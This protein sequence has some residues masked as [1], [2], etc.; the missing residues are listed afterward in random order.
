MRS[1]PFL[2]IIVLFSCHSAKDKAYEQWTTYNGTK[3]GLKYSSL[4]QIDTS[5]VQQLTVAWEYHTG[6]ADTVN[7]SQI[8]CNP[9]M[10]NGILYVISPQLKLAALDAATGQQKW[11]F[12]PWTGKKPNIN[13]LRGLTYWEDEKDKRIFYTA[14]S[15]LYAV[16]ALSGKLATT[17]GDSGLIDLHNDL[18]EGA[19]DLYVITTSPGMIYKDQ[20]IIGSRVSERSDAAPGHIRSYDVHTGKLRWIFHT[21]PQPGEYGFDKWE[22]PEVYKHLGGANAWAGFSLDEERGILFAP[23]GAVSFDFYGGMRQG[24]NLFGNCLVALDANTGKRIWHFQNVHHDVW[25]RDLPAPP[26]LVT[27]THEG[28]KVDAV[29]QVTKTGFVFLFDRLNGHPLFPIEERPVPAQSELSGEKLWATQPYPVLPAPFAR[30]LMTES[31]LNYLLPDSSLKEVKERWAGYRKSHMFE[32][33]STQGSVV[34]PGFDGGPEWGGPAV[35]PETGILYVNSNEMAWVLQIVDMQGKQ[36]KK[37]TNLQAGKRLYRN[38]CMS[39]HG[40][41][42]EGGGNFPSLLHIQSKYTI[43]Q[44][45]ELINTGRRMMPGFSRLKEEEKT[46]IAAFILDLKPE[47]SLAYKGPQE[48]VDSFRNLPYSMTGY[49][50]FLSKEGHPAI[51]PPWGTLNA[52]DLNTGKYVWKDTLGEDP[53]FKDKGIKT[54]TENYGAPVVTAG[55]LLFIAATKDGKMRAFNKRTGQLLWE[56]TLP[57]AGFATPAVYMVNGKQY[58]VIA[59]GGGKLNTK[60]GDSYVAF[61]LPNP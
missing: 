39:C 43:A 30:Q 46:A 9:I 47:Q 55:G 16:D 1:I 14:G 17:F 32:P 61:A 50:K 18:G 23:L 40:P 36:V 27:V 34:L 57:A 38:Q 19:K 56:T 35:D 33:P 25:D 49:N 15:H 48:A 26:V 44:F 52:I 11:V 5:N 22:N 6:D 2:L 45:L 51:S 21:I 20:L 4:K 59:C 54:G 60:S 53:A 37:E 28:K 7:H 29:A 24:E 3:A 8:Q 13:N 10:V 12:D 41:E 31:D 42:R 58:V